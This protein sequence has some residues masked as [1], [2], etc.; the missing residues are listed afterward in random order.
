MAIPHASI[1]RAFHG[2]AVDRERPG[3]RIRIELN[4]VIAIGL[5]CIPNNCAEGPG[6]TRLLEMLGY[7]TARAR[8][9]AYSSLEMTFE[10]LSRSSFSSSSATL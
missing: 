6:S 2:T 10:F 4:A 3:K 5:N 1:L 9:R 8:S 7:W